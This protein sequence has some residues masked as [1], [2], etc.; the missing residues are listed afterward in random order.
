MSNRELQGRHKLV[1]GSDFQFFCTWEREMRSRDGTS[2]SHS[3][4]ITQT[5]QNNSGDKAKDGVVFIHAVQGTQFGQVY[6]S[7]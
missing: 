7:V 2:N 6:S 3:V 1:F 5:L 4:E